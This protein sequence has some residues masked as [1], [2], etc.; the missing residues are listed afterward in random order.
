MIVVAVQAAVAGFGRSMA[1]GANP[2]LD[3]LEITDEFL[4]V[5]I[6]ER[7]QILGLGV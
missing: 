1:L 5:P 4:R 3:G 6:L 7:V 2:T